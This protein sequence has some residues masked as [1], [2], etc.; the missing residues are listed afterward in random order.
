M[1]CVFL[2]VV[3]EVLTSAKC[4]KIRLI[5][6]R[7]ENTMNTQEIKTSD[8]SLRTN[9]PNASKLIQSLR[10]LDY[11]NVSAICDIV[12]NS[13]DA[14]ASQVWINVISDSSNA[15]EK[16]EIIDDGNGMDID[17][18]D[19]A[20]KLGSETGKNAACDLGL[21]GMGLITASISI[22]RKLEVITKRKNSELIIGVQDL[23]IIQ[24]QN[25]FVKTLD[26]VDE[27]EAKKFEVKILSLENKCKTDK[28]RNKQYEN[29]NSATMVTIS[30]IDKCGWTRAKGLTDNLSR[31]ISQ[32]F[33]K[34]IQAERCIF[35]VNGEKLEAIDPI[36]DYEPTLLI[37]D[38]IVEEQ[39]DIRLMVYELK[40]YGPTINKQKGLGIPGQGFY[41]MRNNREIAAGES[42]GVFT[43]HNDFNLLRI[44]F[45]YPA[46]LDGVLNTNFSKQKIK[47]DQSVKNKVERLCNPFIRQVRNK[48]K[49]KQKDNREKK[50]DFSNIEK[51]ITQKSHLLKTPKA[52]I[53]QRDK[54]DE[55][56]PRK[57]AVSKDG[58]RLNITKR[59]RI[60]IESLKVS[61]RSKSLG[62]KAPLYE[63]DQ[64]KDMVIVSWNI[65]H[66]FYQQVVAPNAEDPEIF[67][68]L[69]Y[70]IYCY[71]N[72]ELIAMDNSDSQ[73]IIDNIRWDVGRNLAVLLK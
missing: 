48:A 10:H 13:I 66:P 18:L 3:A 2:F 59:K 32:V 68:P 60:D 24:E 9:I 38:V 7:K 56:K 73:E 50:E 58:P 4:K 51:F 43:K 70:L 14:N 35:Y 1:V 45:S 17:I 44:E 31:T 55:T 27:Q 19:E 33:R 11:D 54:K 46:S 6:I 71:A 12:D 37:D 16:I 26:F 39:G 47:L 20:L 65:D 42:F 67:N 72:S 22:G 29:L 21:Y 23:D 63:P 30:K 40:D 41:V 15:V 34:F 25:A 62:E 8:G 36:M 53:E 52:E 5:L 61:F 28:D 64:E 49:T 57:E 69:A